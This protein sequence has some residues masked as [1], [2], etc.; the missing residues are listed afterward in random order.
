MQHRDSIRDSLI[1]AEIH[2][3]PNHHTKNNLKL[4]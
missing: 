3:I 1:Q 4:Y 2:R